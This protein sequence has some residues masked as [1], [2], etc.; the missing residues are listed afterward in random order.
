MDQSLAKLAPY[1]SSLKTGE[2]LLDPHELSLQ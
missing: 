1:K 2:Q